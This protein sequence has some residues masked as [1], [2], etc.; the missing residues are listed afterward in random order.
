MPISILMSK[1]V[2]MKYL[3]P[4]KPKSAPKLKMLRIYWNWHNWYF[5]Y[6]DLDFDVKNDFY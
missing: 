4:V 2:F 1:I 6:A 3:P 5:K